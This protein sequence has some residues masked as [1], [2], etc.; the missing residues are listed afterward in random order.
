M[1]AVAKAVLE[2]LKD[3]VALDFGHCAANQIVGDMF[4]SHSRM[5]NVGVV[6]LAEP[7]T[8]WRQNVVDTNLRAGR[9]S[10]QLCSALMISVMVAL[11]LSFTSALSLSFTRM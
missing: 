2:R 3:Q 4:G 9:G 6:R 11:S 5:G 8:I 10:H 7:R 1:G